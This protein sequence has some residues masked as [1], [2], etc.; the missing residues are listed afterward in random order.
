ML[1]IYVGNHANGTGLTAVPKL[2]KAVSTLVKDSKLR[3]KLGS[4][5]QKFVSDNYNVKNFL[6]SFES[7]KKQIHDK[8]FIDFKK[9]KTTK[10]V[11]VCAVFLNENYLEEWIEYNFMIGVDII[12][13]YHLGIDEN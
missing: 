12:F 5:G 9:A 10:R 1:G 3:K 8:D 2:V 11:G 7:L 13:L 6:T 4:E